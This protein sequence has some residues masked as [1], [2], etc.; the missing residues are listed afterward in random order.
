MLNLLNFIYDLPLPGSLSN[1]RHQQNEV[2]RAECVVTC[3]Q[4][5]AV[6]ICSARH[7][8]LQGVAAALVVST[9]RC[10]LGS[11]RFIS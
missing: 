3:L 11:H 5:P 2:K 6:S 8:R 10:Q 1:S 4:Q 9:L 7:I